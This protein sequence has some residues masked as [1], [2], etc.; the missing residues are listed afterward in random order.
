MSDTNNISI[1]AAKLFNFVG[2]GAPARSR[3][4][5]L[6]IKEY[7][8]G[9]TELENC[10][11]RASEFAKIWEDKN[12]AVEILADGFAARG[13]QALARELRQALTP[14]SSFDW[15]SGRPKG[16][17]VGVWTWASLFMAA[18]R[19]ESPCRPGGSWFS[20]WAREYQALGTFGGDAALAE[21]FPLPMKSTT[22]WE[23]YAPVLG[24]PQVGAYYDTI[25]PIGRSS[26][27]EQL[28]VREAIAAL[29][30]DAVVVAYGRGGRKAEF[31]QR[32][33]QLLRPRRTTYG[34]RPSR[35]HSLKQD[36]L[37]IGIS[38]RGQLIARLGFPWTRP[39]AHPVTQLDVPILV[40]GL[41]ALRTENPICARDRERRAGEDDFGTCDR[42]GRRNAQNEAGETHCPICD[43]PNG[44]ESGDFD[45]L[46]IP[47]L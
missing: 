10:R 47:Y 34:G 14:G 19:D 37:E 18:W 16:T 44:P 20:D 11:I 22:S 42:C 12:R 31:W 8:P 23:P 33:D 2:Y 27:R 39:N 7:T 5:F 3:F 28:L 30:A 9:G 29:P 43:R 25:L 15:S 24:I 4:L 1:A 21:L 26:P 45:N 32:Y 35:W 36:T 13:E 40:E 38:D 17:S 46:G 41:R 6:G